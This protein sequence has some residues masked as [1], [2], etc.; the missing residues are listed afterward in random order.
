MMNQPTV[1]EGEAALTSP[2]MVN[3]AVTP[4]IEI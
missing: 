4:A 3:G 2:V 1:P